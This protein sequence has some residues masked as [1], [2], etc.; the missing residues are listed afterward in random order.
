VG[1]YT[2]RV[3]SRIARLHH[4]RLPGDIVV[5]EARSPAARLLGLAG[6]RELP[7]RVALRIA[8]CR[9]VH[10]AGMRFPLDLVWLDGAGAVARVDRG[11]P[12][13]R[14]RSCRAARAVLEARAGGGD[15]VAAA[16]RAGRAD[17]NLNRAG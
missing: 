6:T 15:A 16:W 3:Q 5:A 9:S 7:P 4:H 1:A 12:P 2:G 17:A 14:M 13:W 10:T 11:V 8:P